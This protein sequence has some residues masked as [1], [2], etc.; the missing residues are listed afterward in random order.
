MSDWSVEGNSKRSRKFG[1]E[2]ISTTTEEDDTSNTTSNA[3]EETESVEFNGYDQFANKLVVEF[4][5]GICFNIAKKERTLDAS[6]ERYLSLLRKFKIYLNEDIFKIPH[7]RAVFSKTLPHDSLGNVNEEV[8]YNLI[9]DLIFKTSSSL[10]GVI[11]P[12]P[13][14]IVSASDIHDTTVFLPDFFPFPPPPTISSDTVAYEMIELYAM[15]LMRDVPFNSYASYPGVDIIINELNAVRGD[16]PEVTIDNLFK[17]NNLPGPYVSQFLYRQVAFGTY[18][19][20]P[21]FKSYLPGKDY[22]LT[23]PAM[24]SLQNGIVTE[25]LQFAVNPTLIWNL[26]SGITY[27][28]RDE[29]I[30]LA[31]IAQLVLRQTNVPLSIKTNARSQ[32]LLNRTKQSLFNNFGTIDF[33]GMIGAVLHIAGTLCWYFKWNLFRLRPEALS[34]IIDNYLNGNGPSYGIS[35][36]VFE[37]KVL[38]TSKAFFGTYLLSQGYPEGS[39]AHPSY[40]G[41]HAVFAG[42]TLTILKAYYDNDFEI[43]AFEPNAD[44]TALVPLGYKVTIG[45]ELDKLI[46]NCGMFRCGAGIHYN[47]D[48]LGAELGEAIAIKYLKIRVMSYNFPVTLTLRKLNREIIEISNDVVDDN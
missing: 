2:S 16:L 14:K 15:S 13:L 11:V 12:N 31:I 37:S 42:A 41:G 28:H 40:P 22:V 46:I 27:F 45:D 25:A 10:R 5:K 47:S 19:L 24:I 36:A 39:P 1:D 32:D 44:G 17:G 9:A 34:I 18:A 33:Q 43:D 20:N 21:F 7:F 29:P 38:E 23:Y 30:Q 48:C 26:R 8:M 6:R 4:K 35:D 3:T